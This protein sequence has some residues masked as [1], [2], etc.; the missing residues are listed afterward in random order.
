[1]KLQLILLVS[2][3]FLAACSSPKYVYHFDH[4]DYNSGKKIAVAEAVQSSPLKITEETMVASTDKSAIYHQ[5]TK[6][7]EQKNVDA[8]VARYKSMSKGEQK[9]FKSALKKEIKAVVKKEKVK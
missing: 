6:K 8:F 7:L 3:V 2:V 4:Y 5:E 1:M 9:E